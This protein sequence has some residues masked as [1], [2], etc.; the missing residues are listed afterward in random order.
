LSTAGSWQLA[1]IEERNCLKN[2]DRSARATGSRMRVDDAD[3]D[4][5]FLLDNP[6]GLQEVRVVGDHH[7]GVAA[8]LKRIEEQVGRQVHVGALLLGAD[9]LYGS[10][11]DQRRV[12]E[13]HADGVGQVVS[14]MH[15][16]TRDGP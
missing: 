10:R 2:D 13:G 8:A 12:G 4:A 15:H 11:P 3:L 1:R 6:D 9:D 5:Q 14:E 16:D 7:G